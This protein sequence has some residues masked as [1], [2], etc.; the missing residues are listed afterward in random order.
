MGH[1]VKEL[2]RDEKRERGR[3]RVLP[4]VGATGVEQ[5][6]YRKYHSGKLHSYNISSSFLRPGKS[7]RDNLPKIYFNILGQSKGASAART[8]VL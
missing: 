5:E 3:P 2:E 7:V 8:H 4:R 1:G 6:S